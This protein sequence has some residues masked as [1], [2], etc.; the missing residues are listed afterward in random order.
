[1]IYVSYVL[2]TFFMYSLCPGTPRAIYAFNALFSSCIMYVSCNVSVFPCMFV[3]GRTIIFMFL[4]VIV[5]ALASN[6]DSSRRARLGPWP[7]KLC[8]IF[9][10]F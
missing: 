2:F 7:G 1:M 4:N 6:L 10:V 9:S 8:L 5:F 3:F